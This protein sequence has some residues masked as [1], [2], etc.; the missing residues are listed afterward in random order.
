MRALRVVLTVLLAPPLFLGAALCAGA[1]AAA[2]MGGE[3]LRFD[4]LAHFAPIWLTGGLMSL[5]GAL[6]FHGYARA[7]IL[8]MGAAAVLCAGALM[9]PEYLRDIGP[10]APPDAPDQLKIVQMNVWSRNEE[11]QSSVDWAFAQDP[12]I[13]I[14]EETTPA[15]RDRV[16]DRPG[17][18]ATC[19]AC[20]VMILSKRPPLRSGM[21][22]LRGPKPGPLT[23]A[24]FRDRRGTF[25][26]IGVHYAWPTDSSD[27][28]AQEAGLAQVIA[29][30]P[31]ERTIVA[32]DFNSTP[33][34]FSRR[35]WDAEFGLI[36]RDRAL[37]SWPARQYKRLRWLGFFPFL[38]IDHVYAG[39]DWATVK[40]ER[41]PRLGS[42][43]YPVV[44]TLAPVSPR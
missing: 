18:H 10:K 34:S 16:A 31:R 43:H 11:L 5:A 15:L 4:I 29:M 20:E 9:A 3:S 24:V 8:G 25:A 30:S 2:H 32:G 14:F 21:V 38:P 33:W 39:S 36:R 44:V 19:R 28:Q 6:V 35:R 40:V 12:D 22:R 13:V 26:V 1:A 7:L 27:Q 23:R 37:F 17:W 41:G 42:D